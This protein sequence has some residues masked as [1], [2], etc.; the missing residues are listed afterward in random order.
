MARESV[1]RRRPSS[2]ICKYVFLKTVKRINA[3]LCGKVAFSKFVDF[4]KLKILFSVLLEGY[5]S[6][7]L[8]LGIF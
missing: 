6:Q 8:L 7:K 5:S 1:V 3:N 2:F 4:S